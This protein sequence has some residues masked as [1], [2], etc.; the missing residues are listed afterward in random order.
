MRHKGII[1]SFLIRLNGKITLG[2]VDEN[3]IIKSYISESETMYKS[4]KL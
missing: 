1:K 2:L 3:D 4:E